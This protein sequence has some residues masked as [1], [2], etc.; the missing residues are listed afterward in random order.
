MNDVMPNKLP[1]EFVNTDVKI[2]L[3]GK[4]LI[5][6]NKVKLNTLVF[7]PCEMAI[8]K[9]VNFNVI[10]L[11]SRKCI[12][13]KVLVDELIEASISIVDEIL[14]NWDGGDFCTA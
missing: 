12:L 2:F 8:E 9:D 14:Q 10:D 1:I 11:L 7:E 3:D 13:E 4:S 5:I 6:N